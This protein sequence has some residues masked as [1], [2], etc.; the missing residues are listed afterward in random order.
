MVENETLL[1]RVISKK[2]GVEEGGW[3]TREGREGIGVG[4]WKKIRKE[5][6]WLSNYIGF[7]VGNGRRTRFWLD[8]WCGGEAL[9]NSFPSLFALAVS[10]E[11]WVAKVWDSSVDGGSWSPR[12]L[13]AFNDWEVVLVERLLFD[14]AR[15]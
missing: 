2:Y 4:L 11:E 15:N 12:F 3:Y 13:R 1:Y 5:G 8:S 9:C 10:K 14:N 7:S 6:Y